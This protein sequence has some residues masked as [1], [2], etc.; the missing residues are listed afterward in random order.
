MRV[1]LVLLAMVLGAGSASAQDWTVRT[2][3]DQGWFWGSVR[4]VDEGMVFACSG[5][6]PGA[7]PMYGAE[8]APHTPYTFT[9]EL[10]QP[11]LSRPDYAQPGPYVRQDVVLVSNETGYLLPDTGWME[12][13]GERWESYISVADQLIVSLLAGGGLGVW[14]GSTQVGDYGAGGL[15]E[16]LETVIRFCDSHWAQA[17]HGLPAH[18]APV[19]E[20]LRGQAGGAPSGGF[21]PVAAP[22]MEQAALDSVTAHCSGAAQVQA[23]YVLR[24]DFD[25]DGTEDVVLDWRGVS[26]TS[27][28]FANLQGAGNCGM[29][30]CLVSV[31]VSS[32]ISGGAAAW[33]RLAMGAQVDPASPGRLILGSSPSACASIGEAAG[34]ARSYV[35]GGSEFIP[36]P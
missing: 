22:S 1:G 25:R 30:D 34:C 16:G 7:D 20:P 8:D 24:G 2:S 13:N 26:C 9:L 33:E 31:F 6:L 17:G 10:M 3:L 19:I 5:S 23:D 4:S 36:A 18:A 15:A 11:G 32:A 12:L 28:T 14:A 35:W 21:A 27:G 29:H